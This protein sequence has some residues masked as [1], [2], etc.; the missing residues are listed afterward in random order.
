M[1]YRA[2]CA[3]AKRHYTISD[4]G[5]DDV[6]FTTHKEAMTWLRENSSARATISDKKV[7]EPV[8]NALHNV[9]SVIEKILARVGHDK[10]EYYLTGSGNFRHDICT[11]Q[12]YKGNRD[13]LERPVHLPAVRDHLVVRYRADIINGMEADDMLGIRATELSQQGHQPIVVSIDKDLKMIPCRHYN[14]VT[15]E[16]EDVDDDKASHNFYMQ[17]LTGDRTDWIRGIE[18][19]GPVGAAKALAGASSP[20]LRLSAV[21]HAYGAAYPTGYICEDGRVISVEK[22]IEETAQL[23]WIKRSR[24]EPLWT[25]ENPL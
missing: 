1:A 17:V 21:R 9:N 2:A 10:I 4:E 5:V 25:L 11:I 13:E 6:T 23:L 20:R 12:K 15:D 18:G 19:M 16:M 8:Q 14:F 22:A 7:V 24:S 3:A